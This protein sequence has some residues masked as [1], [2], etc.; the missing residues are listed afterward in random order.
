[1]IKLAKKGREYGE[2]R[3]GAVGAEKMHS[4]DHSLLDPL[5]N[6]PGLLVGWGHNPEFPG[7]G[8]NK[9]MTFV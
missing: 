9:E 1:M 4:G 6:I 3:W 8:Y 2:R 5:F 7:T